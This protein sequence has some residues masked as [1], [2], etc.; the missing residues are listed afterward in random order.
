MCA[1][2]SMRLQL[3]L[4]DIKLCACLSYFY[5]VCL[6]VACFFVKLHALQG[7]KGSWTA[8]APSWF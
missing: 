2:T 3:C 4:M 7:V 1:S 8:S 5:S 6:I